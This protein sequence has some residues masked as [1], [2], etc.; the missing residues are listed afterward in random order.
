VAVLESNAAGGGSR[1]AKTHEMWIENSRTLASY[2]YP[3]FW[4]E[5][6]VDQ[7]HA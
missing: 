7:Y 2:S 3:R 1:G 4:A 5:L 6:R